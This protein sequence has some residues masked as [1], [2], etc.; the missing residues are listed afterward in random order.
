[1]PKYRIMHT[2]VLVK[3]EPGISSPETTIRDDCET[4]MPVRQ[5]GTGDA[6]QVSG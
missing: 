1:M 6:L 3:R 5:A 2:G 4:A